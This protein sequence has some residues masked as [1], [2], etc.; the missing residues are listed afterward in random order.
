MTPTIQILAAAVLA[1]PLAAQVVVGEHAS[2]AFRVDVDLVNVLCSVRDST[3]G[4]VSGLGRGE[5]EVREDGHKR[6]V[7]H[8]ATEADAP[9]TVALMVDVSGSVRG[10]LEVERDAARR[11]LDDVL[12]PGDQ[13]LVGGFA[14][15]IAVWQDLTVSKKDLRAGLAGLADR[16]VSHED[17]RERGGTLLYDAVELVASRKL[18]PLPGRKTLVL[19]TDGVDQGSTATS[20]QAEDAAQHADTVVF[21]IHYVPQSASYPA[22]SGPLERLAKATGGRMFD[23]GN[24]MPL[25]RAFAEIAGEMRHQYSL[26]FT[27]GERDGKYHKLEVKVRRSGMKVS[28]REGYWSAR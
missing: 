13:A 6:E 1:A 5:F 20:K 2:G 4:W 12:R 9:L 21:A 17:V 23:V 18:A 15:T 3:G 25:E 26:G 24:K 19:I 10:I 22:G 28:A 27:P 16:A 7:T 14:T 8:F 11:F